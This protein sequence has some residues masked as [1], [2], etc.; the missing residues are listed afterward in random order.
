MSGDAE[1]DLQRALRYEFRDVALLRQALTHRSYVNEVEGVDED[2]ER[3]EFLGDA[4]IDLA[5]SEILM[6]ALPEADEGALSRA[7]ASM[8]SEQG[9]ARQ[10]KALG[11]GA[12]LHLGRGEEA[13]GGRDK[14]SVLADAFEALVAAVHLDGGWKASR[15]L[16]QRF[17]EPPSPDQITDAKSALQSILQAK[18][19]QTPRYRVVESHGP[20]HDRTFVAEVWLGEACLGR[21]SGRSKKAAQ[22][23]AAALVLAELREA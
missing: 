6:D 16:V 1:A 2:N 3:F 20:D 22:Q 17:F 12:A 14:A 10:A 21:G 9:L 19:R 13:S 5:V 18:H 23:R 7:R 8:V 4:V 11:L 15:A